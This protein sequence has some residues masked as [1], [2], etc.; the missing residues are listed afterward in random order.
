MYLTFAC[1]CINILCLLTSS[2][3]YR[4]FLLAP[5]YPPYYTFWWFE[6][7]MASSGSCI[8][9]LSLLGVALLEDWEVWPCCGRCCCFSAVLRSKPQSSTN[10]RRSL[11]GKVKDKGKSRCCA[12]SG[13]LASVLSRTVLLM[14][15]EELPHYCTASGHLAVPLVCVL[16]ASPVCCSGCWEMPVTLSVQL[17]TALVKQGESTG[18]WN[19]AAGGCSSDAQS[20]GG[21]GRMGALLRHDV[22]TSVSPSGMRPAQYRNPNR[23]GLVRGGMPLVWALGF[24]SPSQALWLSLPAACRS[25]CRPLSYLSITISASVLPC[26]LPWW[27]GT[28][29]QNL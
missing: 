4:I 25:E 21:G 17:L 9:R 13:L 19:A 15:C 24:Q 3:T 5:R 7:H 11:L 18:D 10:P 12:V 28:K 16:C 6:I 1:I 29:P 8:W 2:K 14:C 22:T 20:G 27:Q 23:C 26:S